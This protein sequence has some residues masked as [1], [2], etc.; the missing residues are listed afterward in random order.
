VANLNIE[1]PGRELPLLDPVVQIL[2]GIVGV[3]TSQ[4][5]TFLVCQI[6]DALQ[7][8]ITSHS[9]KSEKQGTKNNNKGVSQGLR[10]KNVPLFKTKGFENLYRGARS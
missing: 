5:H 7:A 8:A 6:L 10:I 3:N 4:L 1:G 2:L 9:L